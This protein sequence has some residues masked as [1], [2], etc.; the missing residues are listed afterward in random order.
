MNK[1]ITSLFDTHKK[2][3]LL[4]GRDVFEQQDFCDECKKQVFFNNQ[5]TCKICGVEINGDQLV[6]LRC[7][8]E[9]P[10]F[11][12]ALSPFNYEG[13][14]MGLVKNFKYGNAKYL[15]QVFAKYMVDKLVASN[16]MKITS[17]IDCKI[18]IY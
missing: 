1:F 15:A 16:L 14:I 5:K 6:C 3:C 9:V 10:S 13:R 2:V 4:C 7:G 8:Q 17:V 18:Y 11:D 12:K